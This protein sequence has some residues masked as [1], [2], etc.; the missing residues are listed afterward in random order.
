MVV[1]SRQT[2]SLNADKTAAQPMRAEP[3][4]AL[5]FPDLLVGCLGPMPSGAMLILGVGCRHCSTLQGLS[6]SEWLPV[7]A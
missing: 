4:S 1:V 5:N 7:T 2:K 3:Q 6:G